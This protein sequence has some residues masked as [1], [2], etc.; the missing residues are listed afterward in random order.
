[1]GRPKDNCKNCVCLKC[2]MPVVK[3]FEVCHCPL[4][5]G[6][7]APANCDNK[8]EVEVDGK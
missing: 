1:M 2:K 3:G 5:E 8:R 7:L 4:K 6:R